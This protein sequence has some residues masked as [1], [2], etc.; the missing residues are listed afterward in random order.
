MLTCLFLSLFV[1]LFA[2]LRSFDIH[3]GAHYW[4][5]LHR[6]KV[7]NGRN[8]QEY[9]PLIWLSGF[10]Q[11]FLLQHWSIYMSNWWNWEFYVI[12]SSA[13]HW[14][15]GR[16]V[17]RC[18]H[19]ISVFSHPEQQINR[20]RWQQWWLL[21][22]N[23]LLWWKASTPVLDCLWQLSINSSNIAFYVL[24]HWVWQSGSYS[25]CNINIMTDKRDVSEPADNSFCHLE[26]TQ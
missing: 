18:Q 5:R 15:I 2:C 16:A 13:F 3:A 26:W 7:I 23:S 17:E 1:L 22:I 20:H 8:V 6:G 9:R 25:C 19:H 11:T 4:H 21:R 14:G 12:S 10:V 24:S